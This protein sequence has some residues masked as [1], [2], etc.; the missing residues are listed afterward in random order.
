MRLRF[1][2]GDR[3]S[4]LR[5]PKDNS[6]S[7]VATHRQHPTPFLRG[8][9][10]LLLR[11]PVSLPRGTSR[12]RCVGS[13]TNPCSADNGRRR[14]AL[15]SR[16]IRVPARQ[17]ASRADR[18]STPVSTTHAPSGPADRAIWRRSSSPPPAA[19]RVCSAASMMAHDT[20]P[21][22]RQF[23]GRAPITSARVQSGSAAVKL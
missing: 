21:G 12:C 16:C 4:M 14:I 15:S 17:R 20:E 3:P 2:A 7:W 18:V 9:V 13:G 19:K 6:H 23:L 22:N 5:H 1:G 10:S 8:P 11:G